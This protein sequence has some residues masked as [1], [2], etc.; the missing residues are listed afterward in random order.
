MDSGEHYKQISCL[1]GVK[2]EASEQGSTNKCESRIFNSSRYQSN[3]VT[4]EDVSEERSLQNKSAEKVKY[5]S[6]NNKRL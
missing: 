1:Y 6:T 3:G 2:G 5:N 4:S